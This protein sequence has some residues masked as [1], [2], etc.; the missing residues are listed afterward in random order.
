MSLQDAAW[1]IFGLNILMIVYTLAIFAAGEMSA[2]LLAF[3]GLGGAGW[4]VILRLLFSQGQ[5]FPEGISST[6]FYAV[7]YVGV[8]VFGAI[9]LIPRALRNGL[10]NLP[11]SFLLAPQGIR[12]FFG[13]TFLLWA[14]ESILPQTFGVIDGY[15]HVTAGFLG[16]LAA[17]GADR[18][19]G[20]ALLW[21]ANAFG[22][23]DILIVATSIA[24][25][26]LDEIGAEHPIMYAVFL[27]AP[28]WLW[29]HVVSLYRLVFVDE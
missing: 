4:L 2:R 14:G 22:L 1:L 27:P 20:T 21:L 15:T 26:L 17:W 16:L 9:L 24:F 5:P 10:L 11:Q 3:L 28:V 13:A 18:S 29:L 19:S 12:V 6:L 25:V 23:I 8:A 7:V